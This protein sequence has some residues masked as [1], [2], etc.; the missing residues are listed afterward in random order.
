[1][2]PIAEIGAPYQHVEEAAA[3]GEGVLE[4]PR[5]PADD[6]LPRMA[7]NGDRLHA[8]DIRD[9]PVTYRIWVEVMVGHVEEEE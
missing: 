4:I 6:G 8:G 3:E 2:L 7:Y 5:A 9:G 1:V